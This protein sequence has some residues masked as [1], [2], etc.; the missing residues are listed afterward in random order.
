MDKVETVNEMIGRMHR[1]IAEKRMQMK[2]FCDPIK[3]EIR[4]LEQ[5]ID[6]LMIEDGD[7]QVHGGLL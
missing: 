2:V 3:A 7:Q 6:R 5:N 4:D 1:Q